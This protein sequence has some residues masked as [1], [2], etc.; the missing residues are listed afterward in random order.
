[1][2]LAYDAGST[3]AF[4]L[5]ENTCTML[6]LLGSSGTVDWAVPV[7]VVTTTRYRCPAVG[8]LAVAFPTV[9]LMSTICGGAAKPM[10]TF[11]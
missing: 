2:Q 6:S 4:P 8:T 10:S 5:W 1:M 7:S 9:H 11:P 3:V